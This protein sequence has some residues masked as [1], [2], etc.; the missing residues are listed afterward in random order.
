M[1]RVLVSGTAAIDEKG[2]SLLRDDVRGQI[3]KTLDVVEA[4]IGQ[5]GASLA[6]IC[7]ATVFLKCREDAET[8]WR[9]AEERGLSK[10]PAVC[11]AAD[12]CRAELLFEM[13]AVAVVPNR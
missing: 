5:E 2:V 13:D 12:V 9:V 7:D 4:L 6:D 3:H 10:M 1:T 11:V 8:Y